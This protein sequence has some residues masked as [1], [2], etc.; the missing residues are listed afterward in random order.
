MCP[1]NC[2]ILGYLEYGKVTHIGGNPLDPNSRGRLCAKGIAGIN[3]LYNPDRIPAP[4]KRVGKRGE[5]RWK[6]ISWDE[7]LKEVALRLQALKAEERHHDF[8]IR[9]TWDTSS[10]DIA[11]RFASAFGSLTKPHRA[12]L[13]SPNGSPALE[14]I[15]GH[16]LGLMMSPTLVYIILGNPMRAIPSMYPSS[17][18]W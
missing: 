8:V 6:E 18:G 4:L 7:A 11:G 3:H 14:E 17:R 15:T 5:G 2:G 13:E 12:I 1:A 9:N 10:N 16:E